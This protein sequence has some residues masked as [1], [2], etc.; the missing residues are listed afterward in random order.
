MAMF[1]EIMTL[2]QRDDER[3]LALDILKQIRTPQS[4]SV[5][6]GYLDQPKHREAAA[7]VAVTMSE[8][9]IAARPAEVAAA[10]KQV[11]QATKNK[12]LVD[13]ARGLLNRSGKK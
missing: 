1:R 5:A 12:D 4:L 10:M 9:L 7:R 6:V 2:S 13:K 8:K 3:R 11:L